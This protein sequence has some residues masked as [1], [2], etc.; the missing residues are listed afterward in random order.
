MDGDLT[1]LVSFDMHEMNEVESNKLDHCTRTYIYLHFG[2][3]KLN[4]TKDVG[5]A[6][7]L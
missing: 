6:V 1:L 3:V 4:W 5:F 2:P 7:L